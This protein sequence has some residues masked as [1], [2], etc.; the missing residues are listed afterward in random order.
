MALFIPL[1][2]TVCDPPFSPKV[3][4][5]SSDKMSDRFDHSRYQTGSMCMKIFPFPTHKVVH[6]NGRISKMKLSAILDADRGELREVVQISTEAKKRQILDRAK[7]EVLER[8]RN[9]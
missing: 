3:P 2:G 5:K 8:I 4:R 9:T 1:Q 7:T 6:L